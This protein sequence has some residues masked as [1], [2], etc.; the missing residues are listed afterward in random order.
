[1]NIGCRI[2]LVLV[3]AHLLV[4]S[5][6]TARQKTDLVTL[7]NGGRLMVEIRSLDL[8]RLEAK[9]DEMETVYIDWKEIVELTSE[10][11]FEVEVESGELYFGALEP[12][13]EEG[14]MVV[15][16]DGE[17]VTLEMIRVVLIY[18]LESSFWRRIKGS[19]N[20]GYTLNSG[21]NLKQLTLGLDAGY[22]TRRYHRQLNI[23]SYFS[24]QDNNDPIEQNQGVFAITRNL[25]KHPKW[26]TTAIAAIQQNSELG[27]DYRALGGLSLGRSIV[28]TNQNLFVISAGFVVNSEKFSGNEDT[29]TEED[30]DDIYSSQDVNWE[31]L[32]MVTYYA[33]RYQHPKMKVNATLMVLPGLS[34]TDRLR[35][36]FQG[37]VSYEIFRNFT[38]GLTASESYDSQ[39]PVAGVKSNTYNVGATIGWNFN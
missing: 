14:T 13:S 22:R 15:R 10:S 36:Q 16:G 17:P 35:L 4:C 33:F 21:N 7:K 11:Q 38:V 20:I 5:P 9:T 6:L 8:G 29:G 26:G 18:P 34:N 37:G 30:Q 12:G 23:N 32:L 19:L 25:R 28:Q 2:L 24:R 1:M 39:P 27:L 3:L 31:G